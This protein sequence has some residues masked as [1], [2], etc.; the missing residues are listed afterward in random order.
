MAGTALT[1]QD[2]KRALDGTFTKLLP[3]GTVKTAE[4][5]R[6]YTPS[7]RGDG[8]LRQMSDE[9]MAEQL[10]ALDAGRMKPPG[11]P[12]DDA[13]NAMIRMMLAQEFTHAAIAHRLGRTH[14]QVQNH[15]HVLRREGRL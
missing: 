11:A 1:E 7:H 2:I 8:R 3:D 10:A 9:E 12:W 13:E 4:V 14:S 6:N 5:P 15:V